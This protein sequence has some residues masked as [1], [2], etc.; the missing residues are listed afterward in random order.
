MPDLPAR[1][2]AAARLA[3]L[4]HQRGLSA[5]IRPAGPVLVLTVRNPSVPFG[6]LAQQVALV[7][8]D[9]REGERFVWLFDGAR[10]GTLDAE[11]LGPASDVEA[12]ADR[13][14]RVLTVREA[15]TT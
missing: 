11:P 3:R 10:R 5:A 9:G 12:A 4:L 14:V 2:G 1:D 13:I 7:P 8:G 6:R 15:V